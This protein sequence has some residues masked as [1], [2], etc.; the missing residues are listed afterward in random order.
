MKELLFV[1][2]FVL[3]MVGVFYVDF[4]GNDL[5]VILKLVEGGDKEV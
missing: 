4:M 1:L 2:G 5:N 3:L